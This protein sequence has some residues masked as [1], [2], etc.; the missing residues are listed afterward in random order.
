MHAV[1]FVVDV[2]VCGQRAQFH[3]PISS[4]KIHSRCHFLAHVYQ[5]KTSVERVFV[6]VAY[7]LR[8]YARTHQQHQTVVKKTRATRFAGLLILLH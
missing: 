6:F 1:F 3:A 7:F 2:C 8:L 4:L 5:P